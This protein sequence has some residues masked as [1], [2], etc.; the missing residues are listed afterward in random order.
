M[1]VERV[2]DASNAQYL[3]LE[4][5]I[6]LERC[7]ENSVTLEVSFGVRLLSVSKMLKG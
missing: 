2:D 3:M 4:V 1:L 5:P 6:S 7:V